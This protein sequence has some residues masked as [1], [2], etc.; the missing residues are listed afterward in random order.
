MQ[1]SKTL[2]A[3]ALAAAALVPAA[4]AEAGTTVKLVRGA[5]TAS[6][7]GGTAAGTF[8]LADIERNG[9]ISQRLV[10]SVRGLDAAGAA[11]P[12][13]EV[14]LDDGTNRA[15]LGALHLY[16]SDTRGF[17]YLDTRKATLPDGLTSLEQFSG[18]TLHITL[19]GADVATSAIPAFVEPT[20]ADQGSTEPTGT[21]A[22]GYGSVVLGDTS[23]FG[24]SP[25]AKVTSFAGNSYQGVTQAIGVGA[26]GLAH[27]ET[28]TVVLTAAAEGGTEDVLGTFTASDWFGIGGLV[29]STRHGDAIPGGSVAALAGRGVEIRDSAGAV[30][31][32]GVMPSLN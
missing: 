18:G 26:I 32:S 31:L 3:L 11:D 24:K 4:V 7:E 29:V 30:V 23:Q 19:D 27:G 10:V 21:I 9:T 28:Y 25:V 20:G 16:R 2:G 6:A 15:D 8:R 5:L 14:V 12:Q 17:F 22:F 1:F 13:F